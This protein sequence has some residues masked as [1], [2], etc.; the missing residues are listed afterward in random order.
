[1]ILGNLNDKNHNQKIFYA[2]LGFSTVFL[3]IFLFNFLAT[4]I[5]GIKDNYISFFC[6][7]TY[8]PNKTVDDNNNQVDKS[9]SS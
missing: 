7:N 6:T 2:L 1:M 8:S 3:I 9:S 4:K 5:P